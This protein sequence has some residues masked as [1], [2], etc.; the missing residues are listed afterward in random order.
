MKPALPTDRLAFPWRGFVG[1]MLVMHVAMLA[2]LGQRYSPTQDEIAHLP[3]G[4]AV[5]EFGDRGVYRVNPPLVRTVAA[6]PVLFLEHEEDWSGYRPGSPLRQEW[7]LGAQFVHANGTASQSLFRVARWA[8]IPFSLLGAIICWQWGRE[9]TGEVGGIAALTLW[10]ACPNT[11]GHGALITPDVAAVSTG[12][13]AAWSCQRWLHNGAWDSAFGAGVALGL[14]LL[15]KLYWIVL[16]PLWVVLWLWRGWTRNP[17]VNT[18]GSPSRPSWK[19]LALVLLLGWNVLNLGY[20]YRGFGTKLGELPGYSRLLAG[21]TLNPEADR[22]ANRFAGTWLGDVLVPLPADYVQGIDVQRADF[23][24]GKWSY[25]LGEVRERGWWYYYIAGLAVKVPL[26]TWLLA[27]LG[28]WIAVRQRTGVLGELSMLWLP[29]LCIFVLASSQT[30]MSR[31]VRYVY[32]VLP[33]LFLLGGVA[34]S[35]AA[36][37]LTGSGPSTVRSR[38]HVVVAAVGILLMLG[39]LRHFPHCLSYFNELAGGPLHGDR[40]LIDSNLDWGQDMT[41]VREWLDQHPQARPASLDWLGYVS[42]QSLGIDIP[43][44]GP[45]K[46]LPGWYI[47]S[48]HKLH[49]PGS[50]SGEFL[51]QEPVDRIGCTFRVYRVD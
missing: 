41:L 7:R 9:L 18:P 17:G 15:A 33:V 49:A 51:T 19:K 13:L 44:I 24:I 28:L 34:V 22:P 23:E 1:V 12:L 4:L 16:V 42:T 14:A 31:H 32:P 3:A 47:V 40:V 6:L 25:L 35:E 48:V 43:L 39:S 2:W 20:G 45:D 37:S 26:G 27:G 8:C 36:R 11:L 46:K 38:V 10:C 30:G 29:A 50:F 21:Q 5:W